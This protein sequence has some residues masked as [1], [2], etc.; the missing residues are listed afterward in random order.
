MHL[1]KITFPQL[2]L[3]PRDGH[4][5][6]GFF[7]NKFGE[8]SDLFHNHEAS[9]KAIYRYP[10]IQYKIVNRVPMLVGIEEGGQLLVERFLQMK[11]IDIDGRQLELDQK[12]LKSED[13]EVGVGE[14]L[15]NYQF[16]NPWV[17]LNQDNHKLYIKMSLKEQQ[18]KLHSILISNM[19]GFF[20]AIQH[21]ETERIMVNLQLQESG[22]TQFKNQR[23]LTFKGNFVTNV[24]LPD[25]IGLGKS[26]ARG[27]GVIERVL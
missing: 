19:I 13:C 6:R 15:Y 27:F 26:T 14:E 12:N 9:G 4:K 17:P 25:H 22:D 16:V 5:L 21:Q 24:Q 1:T 23:L 8:E 7:A 11:T 2:H 10:R 18:K 3:H 20:K